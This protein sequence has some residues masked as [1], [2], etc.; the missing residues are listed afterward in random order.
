LGRVDKQVRTPQTNP[1]KK[2]VSAWK[3]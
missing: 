3:S 2:L 1:N